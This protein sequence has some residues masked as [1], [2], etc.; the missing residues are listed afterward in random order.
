[1]SASSF[2][3]AKLKIKLTSARTYIST[4]QLKIKLIASRT[5]ASTQLENKLTSAST[6]GE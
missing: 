1:M 5:F 3:S 4:R 6:F 2:A